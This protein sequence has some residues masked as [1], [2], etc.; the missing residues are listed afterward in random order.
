MTLPL[1]SL[2]GSSCGS[3]LRKPTVNPGVSRASPMN[4]ASRPALIPR[5]PA[6]PPPLGPAR[7]RGE[8][9]GDRLRRVL[10]VIDA[11]EDVVLARAER[12]RQLLDLLPA[13]A[14]GAI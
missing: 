4:P 14:P 13:A 9:L 12:G 2:A 3:W 7:R 5:G 8:P 1:T 10:G 6:F 11:A